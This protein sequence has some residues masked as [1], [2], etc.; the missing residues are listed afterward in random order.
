MYNDFLIFIS[1]MEIIS[2]NKIN[3]FINIFIIN[4]IANFEHNTKK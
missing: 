2:G 1:D 4:K 3:I